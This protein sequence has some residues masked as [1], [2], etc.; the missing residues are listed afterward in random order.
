MSLTI[1]DTGG[2]Q[3]VTST[4]V[5]DVYTASIDLTGATPAGAPTRISARDLGVHVGPAWSPDGRSIA[6]FTVRSEGAPLGSSG[7]R[8]LTVRDLVSGSQRMVPT[9]LRFTGGYSPAWAPDSRSVVIWGRDG[10]AAEHFRYFRVDIASGETVPLVTIGRQSVARSQYS[11]DGQTFFYLHPVTGVIARNLGTGAETIVVPATSRA[12]PSSFT[13]APDER[14]IA[15]V[16]SHHGAGP[17]TL[18]VQRT[19]E[20]PVQL[21]TGRGT[22]PSNVHGWTPDGRSVLFSRG[23][24]RDTES[25]WLVPAQGGPP[26]DLRFT[27]RTT[28]NLVRLSPDGTRIAYTERVLQMELRITELPAPRN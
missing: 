8:V 18:N 24:G 19:G 4:M 26:I 15:F 6:Y 7:E 20:P 2:L 11:A 16:A 27:F 22:P 14:T 3:R 23:A 5:S 1:T 10:P 17:A 13:V 28:P 21:P 9:R 25:L 12:Q